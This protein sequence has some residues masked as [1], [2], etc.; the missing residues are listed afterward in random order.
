M[1]C[2][3]TVR[4]VVLMICSVLVLQGCDW[5]KGKMGMPTSEDIAR[6]KLELQQLEE[7]KAAEAA[8]LQRVQDSL[9]VVE[10]EKEKE[11]NNKIDGFYV[12]LGSFKDYRNADALEALVGKHGYTPQ[13]IMLKNGF[14]MVAVGGFATFSQARKEMEKIGEKDFCPYDMWVY[15]ASQG[16]HE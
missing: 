16:L 4:Y 6:M 15:S 9:K 14:K 11:L 10:M 7:L 5:V 12:V 1:K 13:A 3:E 2:K 8:R